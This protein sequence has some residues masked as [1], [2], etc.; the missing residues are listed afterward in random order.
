MLGVRLRVVFPLDDELAIG[1]VEAKVFGLGV[2]GGGG[3]RLEELQ[4]L[5]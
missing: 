5:W 3:E 2:G 1:V 4:F